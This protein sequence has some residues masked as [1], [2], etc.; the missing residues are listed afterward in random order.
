MKKNLLEYGKTQ[1]I[2]DLSITT[3][4]GNGNPL[5]YS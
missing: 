3:G 2:Q 1:Q 4:K 5:Q